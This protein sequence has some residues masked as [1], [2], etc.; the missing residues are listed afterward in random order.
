MVDKVPYVDARH[1]HGRPGT[2]VVSQNADHKAEA[3]G[4]VQGRQK[5]KH[6]PFTAGAANSSH[7]MYFNISLW[8]S[9]KYLLLLHKSHVFG[10]SFIEL[11]ELSCI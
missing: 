4:Q 1:V 11:I 8:Y 9:S 10:P 5:P 6:V 2:R 3:M 7:I